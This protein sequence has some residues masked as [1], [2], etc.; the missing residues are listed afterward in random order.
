[1]GFYEVSEAWPSVYWH[2]NLKLLLVRYVDDF[3]MAGPEGSLKDGWKLLTEN[4]G[5]EL[6]EIEGPGL[7]LGCKHE[8]VTVTLKNGQTARGIRYNSEAFFRDCVSLYTELAEK[9]TGREVK[10]QRALTPSIADDA[11]LTPPAAMPAYFGPCARC[12]WCHFTFPKDEFDT[13]KSA[14]EIKYTTDPNAKTKSKKTSDASAQAKYDYTDGNATCAP[15]THHGDPAEAFAT[16]EEYLEMIPS[17]K[18]IDRLR[19]NQIFVFGSNLLGIHG[20][21][22]ALDARLK[23]NAILHEGVGRTGDCYAIPTKR[24]HRTNGALPIR[25]IKPYVDIFCDYASDNPHLLF[26]VTEVGCK[27]AGHK[28]STIAPLFARCRTIHNVRLPQSFIDEL[29]KPSD[30]DV[31][32]AAAIDCFGL[33]PEDT[34]KA[35]CGIVVD[36]HMVD[37]LGPASRRKQ[38]GKTLNKVKDKR[39]RPV[40][41]SENGQ[42]GKVASR[43]LMKILYGARYARLDLLYATNHLAC[44]VTKWDDYCDKAL[45]RLVSYIHK[46]YHYRQIGYIGDEV[47]DLSSRY[48]SDA[49]FAACPY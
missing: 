41:K 18:W 30:I 31:A 9:I 22:A 45:F 43:V 37:R 13:Y 32:I 44:M 4:N 27:L 34:A 7:F 10:M 12:P 38:L 2:D 19:P 29:T 35:D 15:I 36:P 6:G 42:L 3:K 33:T 24:T 14:G 21:G 26:L 48:W 17:P 11:R 8:P 40:E 16:E 23:F 5:I 1:M 39:K 28:P 49:S 20:A 25:Q 47:S 46:T